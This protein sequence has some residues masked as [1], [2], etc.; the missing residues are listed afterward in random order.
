MDIVRNVSVRETCGDAGNGETVSKNP[1]DLRIHRNSL[2]NISFNDPTAAKVPAARLPPAT[3]PKPSVDTYLSSTA[4]Q[5]RRQYTVSEP[6]EDE[7]AVSGR[8][9]IRVVPQASALGDHSPH[10][11]DES[12]YFDAIA[13]NGGPA[14]TVNIRSDIIE[15]KST[16]AAATPA[17]TVAAAVITTEIP[18]AVS[19]TPQTVHATTT[20]VG[21]AAAAAVVIAAAPSASSATRTTTDL[22]DAALTKCNTDTE[23]CVQLNG[24]DSVDGPVSSKPIVVAS[25]RQTTSSKQPLSQMSQSSS[26]VDHNTSTG[27]RKIDG[28][29]GMAAALSNSRIPIFNPNLR[30]LKCASWAGGDCQHSPEIQDLTPGKFYRDLKNA[31]YINSSTF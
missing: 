5:Y 23:P 19:T 17:A 10:N 28:G 4:A 3:A 2:P 22:C 25:Q 18:A 13:A 11:P 15:L 26:S 7:C 9:E 21:A 6:Q 20:T 8:L 16:S 29:G 27:C 30:I 24:D 14:A 1:M 12:I 31:F